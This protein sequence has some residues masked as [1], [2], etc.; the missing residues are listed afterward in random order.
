MGEKRRLTRAG[1]HLLVVPQLME[2]NLSA[3]SRLVNKTITQMITV[4]CKNLS[5]LNLQGC[6]RIPADVLVDLVERLTCLKKLDL[7]ETQCNTQVLSAVGSCCRQLCELDISDCKKLSPESLLHLAYDPTVGSYC[8]PALQLLWVDGLCPTAHSQDLCWIL[9]FLL[10]ALP[11][12]RSLE[13]EFVPE[14]LCLL[15]KQQFNRAPV[16][17]G[18]P[19]LE[20][21]AQG[22]MATCADKARSWLTLPLREMI[23]VHEE[24]LPVVSAMCPDLEKVTVNLEEDG[25]FP[26]RSF[27]L[28]RHLTHLTLESAEVRALREF[29]P[30]VASLG[31]QLQALSLE[32]FSADDEL[33][34]H[35]LLG[36]CPNLRSL[37][38]SLLYTVRPR[39][40]AEEAPSRAVSLAALAFPD[41][42]E[43]SLILSD[44]HDGLPFR[45]AGTLRA[46]LVSLLR[47]APCLEYLH[48]VDVPF[49]L[50]EVFEAVLEPRGAALARLRDLSLHQCKVSSRTI[51]LLLSSENLLSSLHLER[52]PDIHRKDYD[53]LLRRVS[54]EGFELQVHWK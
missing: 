49:C 2:L 46:S 6:S 9:A 13:N 24:A 35:T 5:S 54:K 17:P 37:T 32:G 50:D 8:C 53:K 19:S 27:L 45:Q 26:S 7:S 42:C 47:N 31:S 51:H 34:F 41:L 29:F 33:A 10:L 21:V 38:A 43:F 12:L 4:R 36:H 11:S 28:W 23:E 48:L 39:R 16:T 40:G 18:F 20:E 15:Q 52:C 22:R 30:V 25:P 44:L 3:C 14:A 1:L